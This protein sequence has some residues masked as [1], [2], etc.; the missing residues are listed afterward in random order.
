[1]ISGAFYILS[2][3][4]C[5][6]EE[7][8]NASIL[9]W[10]IHPKNNFDEIR[11]LS[12]CIDSSA[13]DTFKTQKCSKDIVKIVHF[14]QWFNHNFI[15]KEKKNNGFIQQFFSEFSNSAVWTDTGK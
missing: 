14:H 11:E 2:W 13:T 7:I 10:R 8:A 5:T 3:A 1:M 12:D 9:K 15:R 4:M 6:H